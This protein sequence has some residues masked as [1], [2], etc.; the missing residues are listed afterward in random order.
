MLTRQAARAAEFRDSRREREL[1]STWYSKW[2]L[3]GQRCS[4]VSLHVEIDV[5]PATSSRS[6]ILGPLSQ[7]ARFAVAGSR[8]VSAP[9]RVNS[10][11]Q[12]SSASGDRKSVV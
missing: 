8:K 2:S 1:T 10:S 11:S 9:L 3:G 7:H 5:K 6:R 12:I 4:S